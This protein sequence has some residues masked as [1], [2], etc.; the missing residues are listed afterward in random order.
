MLWLDIVPLM[1]QNEMWTIE[2]VDSPTIQTLFGPFVGLRMFSFVF[3]TRFRTWTGVTV[4]EYILKFAFTVTTS[5]RP[6]LRDKSQKGDLFPVAALWTGPWYN[7]LELS[8]RMIEVMRSKKFTEPKPVIDLQTGER[9]TLHLN[10]VLD[11]GPSQ[12]LLTDA[13]SLLPL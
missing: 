5:G 3:L 6:S 7:P 2:M 12:F 11:P 9:V 4:V 1:A 13:V 8:P 10:Q